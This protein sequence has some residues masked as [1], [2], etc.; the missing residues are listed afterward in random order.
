[1]AT[2]KLLH[3][4]DITEPEREQF[5]NADIGSN[6]H[7]ESP[8][9]PALFQGDDYIYMFAFTA[10]ERIPL[11]YKNEF[12]IEEDSLQEVAQK[13]HAASLVLSREIRLLV[14]PFSDAEYELSLDDLIKNTNIIDN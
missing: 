10:E 13:M 14:D 3:I 12:V 8:M 5:K 2:L 9:L 11:K 1:M 6:V 7:I 4:W